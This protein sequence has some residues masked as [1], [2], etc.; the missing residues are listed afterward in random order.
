MQFKNNR[1]SRQSKGQTHH[2]SI[3][4]LQHHALSEK[5]IKLPELPQDQL[6]QQPSS[7]FFPFQ[8][9]AKIV[10]E[11]RSKERIDDWYKSHES[12]VVG[13]LDQPPQNSKTT[14]PFSRHG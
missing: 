2:F 13:S 8:P 4:K 6:Q 5:R 7:V 12:V 11:E 9:F 10:A 1:D 3:H 14:T